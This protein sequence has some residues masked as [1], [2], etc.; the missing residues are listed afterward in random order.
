MNSRTSFFKL[1]TN[2]LNK[3]ILTQY[4]CYR[5]S[6]WLMRQS[7]NQKAVPD[8]RA[9]NFL[10]WLFTKTIHIYFHHFQEENTHTNVWFIKK[11]ESIIEIDILLAVYKCNMTQNNCIIP[12]KKKIK[13]CHTYHNATAFLK[14]HIIFSIICWNNNMRLHLSFIADISFRTVLV[15]TPGKH[16]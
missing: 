5:S 6:D 12:F 11:L 7:I 15:P 14:F 16:W 13:S 1:K 8:E 9:L 2:L 4:T 10:I 3:Y